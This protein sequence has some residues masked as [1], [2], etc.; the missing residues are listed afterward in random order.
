[1][2]PS[3]LIPLIRRSHSHGDRTAIIASD[4]VFT[5]RR[6]LD[7]SARVASSLLAGN[8]DLA[9]QRVPYLVP[10]RFDYVAIQ[11][12][13]WRAG[14]VAVPLCPQHPLPELRHV[15]DDTEASVVVVHPQ[16]KSLLQP[17]VESRRIRLVVTDEAF[18]ANPVNLPEIQPQRRA[19]MLYTSGT[20]AKP[21]G[22]VITH[23]NITAQITALIESW[24]WSAE[25]VILLVLPLHHIHGIINVL[26][27]ALWAGAKCE[28]LELFDAD[29]VWDRFVKG[30][31]TLFMAVPTIYAKLIS[32]GEAASSSTQRAMRESC[33][34][35][36]LMVSGSAALPVTTLEKW[37]E[38]SGHT[39]LERYGMTEI[40]MA[41]SNPLHGERRP[42]HVGSP[43][44]GVEVRLIADDGRVAP[45]NASGEI[46]VRG[47]SVFLEYWNQPGATRDG[48]VNGW[49]KTGDIATRNDGIYRILGRRSVD[50]IKSGGEKVSALEIE[51]VLCSHEAIDECAVVGLA[52]QQWGQRVGVAIVLR[53]GAALEIEALRSW[54]KERLATYKVPKQMVM[55]DELPRNAMGKVAKPRV[56][57]LFQ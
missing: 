41:L 46:Q 56:A 12:G 2:A 50:I 47:S 29:L 1:M 13:I 19:M 15:I 48:F 52:D 51:H 18:E 37:R 32:A 3:C 6:L 53:Q 5:Y 11:W 38:I 17:L 22:V 42:G 49:F 57:E 31:L 40:G 44:P 30:G 27:C 25:D 24:A 43:L 35:M 55:V 45:D 28:M 39:L 33:K 20:T 21:K 10:S 4:G 16:Y 23:E 9:E 34:R 26:S 36:R 54:C 7:V 8:D 14:G